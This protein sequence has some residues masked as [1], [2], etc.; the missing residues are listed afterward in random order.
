MTTRVVLGL[1]VACA[2]CHDHKFEAIPQSDYYAM[3]GIFGS[4]E[5]YFGTLDTRRNRRASALLQLPV[6]DPNPFDPSYTPAELE[7]MSAEQLELERATTEG[8]RERLRNARSDGRTMS[9]AEAETVNLTRMGLEAAL[10]GDRIDSVDGEGNPLS[11]CMGVQDAARPADAR[12]LARGDVNQPAEEVP[13]G[14]VQVL[15][16]TAGE[17]R[18]SPRARAAAPSWR[19]GS[20]ATTIR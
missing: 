16:R 8:R 14:F 10:L 9:A 3:A 6:D 17:K 15:E 19:S 12:L 7:R 4:T 13:R 5:T 20:R 2:R 1:S 18:T 11:F